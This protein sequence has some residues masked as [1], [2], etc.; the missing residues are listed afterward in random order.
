MYCIAAE[1]PY[2]QWSKKINVQ[3]IPC[4]IEIHTH[5]LNVFLTSALMRIFLSFLHFSS[6][7]KREGDTEV[8]SALL[9]S[10]GQ[11]ASGCWHVLFTCV[12]IYSFSP[13]FLSLS[14]SLS[15]SLLWDRNSSPTSHA[16]GLSS[17]PVVCHCCL[18][19]GWDFSNAQETS[20]V[21]Q[22]IFN[23]SPSS[24]RHVLVLHSLLRFQI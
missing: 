23:S 4:H 10:N 12:S 16:A 2:T 19:P 9:F 1:H 3:P 21:L 7:R 8:A 17:I 11:R 13:L 5:T 22:I 15:W 24:F 20:E 6:K 14:L 18:F